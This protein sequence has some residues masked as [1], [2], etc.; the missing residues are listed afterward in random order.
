MLQD[1]F[2]RESV[3]FVMGAMY[4]GKLILG[5]SVFLHFRFVQ[6]DCNGAYHIFGN[7]WFYLFLPCAFYEIGI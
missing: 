3:L 6:I 2:K 1:V 7:D 4:I 5:G